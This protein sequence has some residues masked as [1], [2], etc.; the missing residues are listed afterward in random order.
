MTSSSD[1]RPIGRNRTPHSDQ[2]GMVKIL[3]TKEVMLA[4]ADGTKIYTCVDEAGDQATAT[5]V[6]CHGMGEHC[7]RYDEHVKQ[8]VAA[9]FNV[10]RFDNRG[11]GRSGGKRGGHPVV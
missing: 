2:Q 1:C 8:L 4:A 3:A 9:G 7:R 5:V 10:L 11:H 6:I